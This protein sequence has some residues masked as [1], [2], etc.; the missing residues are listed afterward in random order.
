MR[1]SASV[2][3][4]GIK[5]GRRVRLNTGRKLGGME[6]AAEQGRGEQ[7]DAKEEGGREEG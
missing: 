3:G 6:G 4:G 7:T 2:K 1:L 5:R